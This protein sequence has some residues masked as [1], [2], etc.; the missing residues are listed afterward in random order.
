M[1]GTF[2]WIWAK[3]LWLQIT[4][5]GWIAPTLTTKG[6]SWLTTPLAWVLT[7]LIFWFGFKILWYLLFKR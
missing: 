6:V 7:V 5:V 4:V 1:G 3:V 2:D